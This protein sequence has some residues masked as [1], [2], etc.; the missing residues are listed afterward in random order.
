MK[1][2]LTAMVLT[3][4]ICLVPTMSMA[5]EL[6][7]YI[8]PGKVISSHPKFASVQK[9]IAS[10][11]DQKEKEVDTEVA[12]AK[13][14]AA[15]EQIIRK[16]AREVADKE[17]ALMTPIFKDVSTATNASAKAN[18]VSVV[19]NESYIVSGGKDLTN[20]VIARLK[21]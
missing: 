5:A 12:K 18:G 9:Q 3:A 7:G 14:D 11:A 10:F 15:K 20:D 2:S 16:K 1:K 8:N 13:D 21:K 6:V 19:V 17:N 4:A